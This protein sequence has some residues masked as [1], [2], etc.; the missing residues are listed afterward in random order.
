MTKNTEI[1]NIIGNSSL[2]DENKIDI[3]IK[4]LIEKTFDYFDLKNYNEEE[5]KKNL[6]VII[7]NE[8]KKRKKYDEESALCLDFIYECISNLLNLKNKSFKKNITETITKSSGKDYDTETQIGLKTVTSF[9]L[10]IIPMN[11]IF[12]K[13]LI[14][15]G[16]ENPEPSVIER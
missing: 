9:K 14:M 8:V 13:K 15:K 12:G 2:D 10:G 5:D 4:S 11:M 7:K 16:I 3:Q 6:L 1:E